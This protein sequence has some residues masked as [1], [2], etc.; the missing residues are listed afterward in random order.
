MEPVSRFLLSAL[1]VFNEWHG[2]YYVSE[3]ILFLLYGC[4]NRAIHRSLYERERSL[5]GKYQNLS[6]TNKVFSAA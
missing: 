2:V 3:V 4:E 1:R 6:L 5:L